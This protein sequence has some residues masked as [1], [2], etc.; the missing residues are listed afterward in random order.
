MFNSR[1]N[2]NELSRVAAGQDT[3]EY[4]D[5]INE[6]TNGGDRKKNLGIIDLDKAGNP[7]DHMWSSTQQHW[8]DGNYPST[9]G[10]GEQPEEFGPQP[11]SHQTP[12]AHFQET[13]DG[14][15]TTISREEAGPNHPAITGKHVVFGGIKNYDSGRHF[16]IH[17]FY[18]P[19]GPDSFKLKASTNIP[20]QRGYTGMI[21][22]SIVNVH[23][24]HVFDAQSGLWHK[25]SDPSSPTKLSYNPIDLIRNA[26]S[27]FADTTSEWGEDPTHSLAFCKTCHRFPKALHRMLS[28]MRP[29]RCT[30]CGTKGIGPDYA[31]QPEI[32]TDQTS[33]GKSVETS[34]LRQSV[35][36]RCGNQKCTN[37]KQ[38]ISKDPAFVDEDYN[39]LYPPSVKVGNKERFPGAQ[40]RM[41]H[42]LTN[43]EK[44]DH[45]N[46]LHKLKTEGRT[47]I[48]KTIEQARLMGDLSENGDY[49]AAK[50]DQGKME[51]RIRDLE[52]ILTEGNHTIISDDKAREIGDGTRR[53][54][55]FGN[56]A[57]DAMVNKI[58]KDKV[59]QIPLPISTLVCDHDDCPDKG[60]PL[61]T[62]IQLTPKTN[63]PCV[64]C[65]RGEEDGVNVTNKDVNGYVRC[66]PLEYG[67]N[68]CAPVPSNV[69]DP[70]TYLGWFKP[71]PTHKFPTAKIDTESG[72][73]IF[74]QSE[75]EEQ[76]HDSAKGR[77]PGS[78]QVTIKRPAG[79]T[80]PSG[81]GIGNMKDYFTFRKGHIPWPWLGMAGRGIAKKVDRIGDRHPDVTKRLDEE[82]IQPDAFKK[83]VETPVI[84][85]TDFSIEGL[86]ELIS[87]GLSPELATNH[88]GEVIHRNLTADDWREANGGSLPDDIPT[89]EEFR[90]QLVEAGEK[91]GKYFP[92]TFRK[93]SFRK[94]TNVKLSIS[95]D[96]PNFD[97]NDIEYLQE[98]SI[99]KPDIQD[100]VL[101]RDNTALLSGEELKE[102]LTE[103]DC[104]TCHGDSRYNNLNNAVY[105]DPHCKSCKNGDVECSSTN[106]NKFPHCRECKKAKSGCAGRTRYFWRSLN[107]ICKGC[108]N[109]GTITFDRLHC[110]E[111]KNNKCKGPDIVGN[112]HCTG[113][114]EHDKQS[115]GEVHDITPGAHARLM[116]IEGG[117]K[118]DIYSGSIEPPTPTLTQEEILGT[119]TNAIKNIEEELTKETEIDEGIDTKLESPEAVEYAKE[120]EAKRRL[121][122]IKSGL[123]YKLTPLEEN[124]E[125]I[126]SQGPVTA[127]LSG[128]FDKK[129]NKELK[130]DVQIFRKEKSTQRTETFDSPTAL[131]IEEMLGENTIRQ[132]DQD[133]SFAPPKIINNIP[134]TT[135]EH[136]KNCK[137]CNRGIIIAD[138]VG[139][140]EMRR[141]NGEIINGI[142]N[143][144]KTIPL[145]QQRE[146]IKQLKINAY[147][148]KG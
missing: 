27:D 110:R 115:N 1:Y 46:E 94:E 92:I 106:E 3:E 15:P 91:D 85:D 105:L 42:L 143:I 52:H 148:C 100:E 5:L 30:T 75:E 76:D 57:F 14:L 86:N 83:I 18:E 93:K 10:N 89:V 73:G 44:F 50:D 19:D 29:E 39:V 136:D 66:N 112:I 99:P 84:G 56:Y 140:D 32:Y 135:I 58:G 38:S 74:F 67:A 60:L 113:C 147:K 138:V 134:V 87:K 34:S 119:P 6:L 141:I 80:D 62:H 111:C 90:Q 40:A 109:K 114:A 129:T 8:S 130:K 128:K 47:E 36:P 33:E 82:R 65:G 124:Y 70:E 107:E 41:V 137:K 121:E 20:H 37:Y 24:D 7:D 17:L 53:I 108:L 117:D 43:K 132:D 127:L 131:N 102:N 23:D 120:M 139:P 68:N 118:K 11:G 133:K 98:S 79:G 104:P 31:W 54:H 51:S 25:P 61:V 101:G 13:L 78:H 125:S 146:A 123:I 116:E 88:K 26:P 69:K 97:P 142:S 4:Q 12:Y 95:E 126:Q 45:K 122:D 77:Y 59:R 22:R 2:T 49:H 28:L 96:D 103:I 55:E 35:G 144:K 63:L 72:L 16:D 71:D 145:E 81:H 48:A 9:P 21:K 64:H